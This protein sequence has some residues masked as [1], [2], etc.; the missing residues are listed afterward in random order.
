MSNRVKREVVIIDMTSV[1]S[2]PRAEAK[3]FFASGKARLGTSWPMSD[4]SISNYILY[5]M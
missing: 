3:R 5:A 2:L 1:S 4:L